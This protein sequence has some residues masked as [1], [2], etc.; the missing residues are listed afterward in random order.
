MSAIFAVC[1]PTAAHLLT[2]GAS[3][4]V[5]NG[6]LAEVCRKQLVT[7][8]RV[9]VASI[10]YWDLLGPPIARLIEERKDFDEAVPSLR[11]MCEVVRAGL[12]VTGLDRPFA[13]VIAGWSAARERPELHVCVAP[14][15]GTVPRPITDPTT[16][17]VQGPLAT[18]AAGPPE[19]D[20]KLFAG[21]QSLFGRYPGAF[22]PVRTGVTIMKIARKYPYQY[23]D[24]NWRPCVGGHVLLTTLTRD[25][26]TSEVIH[27]WP[28][29]VGMPI[30]LSAQ[31]SP[32][33]MEAR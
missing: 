17:E 7:R 2:D 31:A 25:S 21:M 15:A 29:V 16:F 12:P 10:G 9:A 3:T 13:I 32:A 19:S 33:S 27:E 22:D 23:A 4:H 28:D 20:L 30:Q 24:G 1:G 8:N 14:V 26:I 11:Q 18:F 6:N 5:A